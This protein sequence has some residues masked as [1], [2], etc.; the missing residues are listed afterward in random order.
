MRTKLQLQQQTSHTGQTQLRT[1]SGIFQDYIY[2]STPHVGHTL[3]MSF[4]GFLHSIPVNNTHL[5]QGIKKGQFIEVDTEV[6]VGIY[7][8]LVKRVRADETA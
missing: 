5:F 2:R 7:S 6:T 1:Y 8:E 3:T 4:G